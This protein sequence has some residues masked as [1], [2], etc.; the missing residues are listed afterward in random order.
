MRVGERRA[1]ARAVPNID[2]RCRRRGDAVHDHAEGGRAAQQHAAE[3]SGAAAVPAVGGELG[4]GVKTRAVNSRTPAGWP[5]RKVY[6]T[7]SAAPSRAGPPRRRGQSVDRVLRHAVRGSLEPRRREPRRATRKSARRA[8]CTTRAG[9]EGAEGS[10]R[11]ARRFRRR[12]RFSSTPTDDTTIFIT[13]VIVV[14]SRSRTT[15]RHDS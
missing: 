13:Y 1:D 11:E 5:H 6:A 7:G 2:A 4:A 10:A 12:W 14:S 8:S 15:F 9:A 3:F